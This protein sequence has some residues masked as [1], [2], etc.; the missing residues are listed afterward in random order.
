MHS[1]IVLILLLGNAAAFAPA[2]VPSVLSKSAFRFETI[3]R[4]SEL[5]EEEMEELE[6]RKEG[7]MLAKKLRSNMFNENGVAYAPWMVDQI[8]EEAYEAAKI[9]RKQRKMK[10][11]L[12]KIEAEGASFSTDLQADEISGLG[13]K[14]KVVDEEVELTWS[15]AGESCLGY[16]V[17][18]RAARTDSWIE[19]GSYENWAPLQSKGKEGGV[20]TFMDP[21]SEVGDWIYRVVDVEAD[22]KSTVLCQAMVEVQSKGEQVVQYVTLAGFGVLFAGLVAA[23]V[24]FDPLQ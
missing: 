21:E 16:K 22:G 13:L 6:V 9:M 8:D 10:Q 24:F 3:S 1:P 12:E 18:K 20:Y 23:G 11:K 14:Y 15:T 2:R 7:E 5:D 19:S 17:Q 4:N